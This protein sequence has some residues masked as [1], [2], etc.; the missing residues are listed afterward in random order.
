M[1]S[2]ATL[3]L[4]LLSL[5]AAPVQADSLS[6]T[7]TAFGTGIENHMVT[8]VD[9]AFTQSIGRLYFWA[10]VANAEPGDTVYHTWSIRGWVSQRIAVPVQGYLFR[11]HTFKTLGDKMTGRWAVHVEDNHGQLLAADTVTVRGD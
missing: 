2:A 6:V 3:T 11:T 10:L 9:T 1:K 5:A 4:M 7:N 8:G